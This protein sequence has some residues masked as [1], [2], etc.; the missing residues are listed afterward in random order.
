[1]Y[2]LF[3]LFGELIVVSNRLFVVSLSIF[4]LRYLKVVGMYVNVPQ[5]VKGLCRE[6]KILTRG[7]KIDFIRSYEH[8]IVPWVISISLST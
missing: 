3:K 6:E 4:H 7:S 5:H 8:L 2:A 1:M